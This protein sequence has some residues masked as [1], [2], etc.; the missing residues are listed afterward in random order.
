MQ[1][2]FLRILLV[3]M[4]VVVL[5]YTGLAVANEGI[6]LFAT[7]LP[8][9]P[10]FG[11]P[12]QFHLDFA[13]YLILSALWVGWRHK[14]S[15]AGIVLALIASVGGMIFLSIYLLVASYKAEGDMK[16]ILLGEHST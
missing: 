5:I 13:T 10:H 4:L 6:N 14:F 1:M 2:T 8:A 15:P 12:G 9:L 7:T 16:K 11:W 3:A